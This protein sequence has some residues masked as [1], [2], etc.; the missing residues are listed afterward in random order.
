M[1]AITST[2][3]SR[4]SSNRLLF[5]V[6]ATLAAFGSYFCM[7]AF[8]KPFNA[9]TYQGHTFLGLHYKSMLV[10]AQV[11]GYM[12]SKF[13][14]IKIISEL[15]A[16][17]R[18]FLIILLIA[19]AEVALLLF[20]LVP[21]P[22]NIVCLFLNGLPLGMVWGIVFSYLEG[23]RFTEI[24]A[25]GLSVSQIIS[26][27]C[28]KTVYF[29]VREWWPALPE[30][31]LPGVIG[32]LF[33]P[34]FIFFVWMLSVIPA[35]SES[36]KLLRAERLPMT[37]AEKKAVLQRFGWGLLGYVAAYMLLTTIRDFRDNFAVEIWNEIEPGWRKAVF[38]Q[39]EMLSGFFV[40]LAIAGLSA[41]RQNRRGFGFIQLML[42]VG[43]ALSA[44]SAWAF[45]AGKLSPF[46]WMLL[47]GIGLFLAYVPM[48]IAL[49]ERVIGLFRLR[50]NAG[51]FVYICDSFGYLGSV[52]LVLYR[53][54]GKEPV[55]WT[56][57]LLQLSLGLGASCLLLLVL[58]NIFFYKKLKRV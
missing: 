8:R 1:H 5:V 53:A 46:G 31:W 19:V 48:Q 6:W 49:F 39:T 21:A 24:L 28:L 37:V 34:L 32:L 3:S 52:G 44:L 42:A 14:G 56:A 10:I 11:L 47:S 33:L 20:G 9:G 40:L 25:V 12:V 38:S 22:Y 41:I 57:T 35:P 30:Y 23:R 54:L 16:S 13:I 27:G 18:S 51:F 4:L 15:K 17:R 45:Q 43:I 50:A 2:I 58:V 7:Y 29:E 36:D 55:N 26:S